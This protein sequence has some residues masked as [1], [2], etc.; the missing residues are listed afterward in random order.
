MR[1]MKEAEK[2]KRKTNSMDDKN[3]GTPKK[4]D[5]GTVFET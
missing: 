3:R 5:A 2:E 4:K 1:L